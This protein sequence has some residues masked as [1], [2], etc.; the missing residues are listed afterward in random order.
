MQGRRRARASLYERLGEDFF[1]GLVE[2]FY[3]GVEGDP[4]LRP[5]YPADLTASRRHLALFLVQYFGGPASYN[6]LRGHPRLRMRHFRFGIGPAER[7]AWL[8]HMT[9]AV[10]SYGREP[11]DEEELLSYFSSTA[12]MLTSSPTTT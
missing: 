1:V 8:R 6:A 5:L 9:E 4:V 7:D 12:A 10:R 3:D 2:R 11:A